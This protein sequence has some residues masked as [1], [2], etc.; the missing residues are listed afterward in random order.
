M[1]SFPL[2]AALALLAGG[3]AAQPAPDLRA[4]LSAATRFLNAD[5]TAAD[6]IRPGQP[7]QIQ[8]ALRSETGGLPRG[9]A[10]MAWLRPV[11]DSDLPCAETAAAYRA[12]GRAAAGSVDLNG[13]VLGV[14]N[15]DGALTVLDPDRSLGTANLVSAHRFSGPQVSMATDAAGGVFLVAD[16]DAGT[17]TAVPPLGDP[18]V[19]ARG[20]ARPGAIQPAPDGG[21]WL[22]EE[23]SGDLLRVTRDGITLRL[24]VKA[25]GLAVAGRS[26]AVLAPD[27]VLMLDGQG[28]IRHD[29]PAPGARAVGL[30]PGQGAGQGGDAL[31]WLAG[32]MLHVLWPDAGDEAVRIPVDPAHDRLAA[33]PGGRFVLAFGGGGGRISVVDLAR[34]RV[35]QAIGSTAPVAEI[36][37]IPGTAF[38]RTGDG[39]TV[40]IMD[41]RL[42]APGREA[43][44][45]QKAIGPPGTQDAA[46]PDRDGDALLVPLLPE[47][48]LLAVH[49][50]SYTGFVLDAGHATSGKP[51][52]EAL[53]LRGGIPRQ[54]R[55]LDAGLRER[56]PGLF[57]ATARLPQ[58]VPYELVVSAGVGEASFCAPVPVRAAPLAPADLPGTV[59]LRRQGARLS[60][61]LLD[62]AGQPVANRSG[63]LIFQSLTGNWR[64]ASDFSTG[65]DGVVDRPFPAFPAPVAVTVLLAGQDFAPLVMETLP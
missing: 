50:G 8:V 1:A 24:A 45:G 43:A 65:P 22:I 42:A 28:R 54:V 58:A 21:A 46:D 38:L 55:A 2:T 20:L 19:L 57:V 12:T 40:G 52:M 13:L 6:A 14:L 27:R 33:D 9:I 44:I 34:S 47:P 61:R 59:L 25:R 10:P 36:A 35:V 30:R 7:F 39:A 26:V 53:R 31:L 48:A 17:V 4:P 64:G 11:A 56:A 62:G 16:A 18:A 15:R 29:L 37:F 63:R 51:P 5:G 60:L 3:A 41:L 49:A 23:G 32:G